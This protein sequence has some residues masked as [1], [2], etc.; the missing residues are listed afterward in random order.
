MPFDRELLN[1][2]ARVLN[3]KVVSGY[4][5]VKE[6]LDCLESG[7]HLIIIQELGTKEGGVI[8]QEVLDVLPADVPNIR[9]AYK[10]AKELQ[11]VGVV[12]QVLSAVFD[13][14]E[15]EPVGN[16]KFQRNR[17]VLPA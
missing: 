7:V 11:V 14:K 5:V 2:L 10:V 12:E 17:F 6:S 9:I 4:G 1:L 16:R 8:N 3:D 13:L 15:L